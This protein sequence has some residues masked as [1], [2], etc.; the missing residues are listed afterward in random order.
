MGWQTCSRNYN[1]HV[2]RLPR[3]RLTVC[4]GSASHKHVPSFAF[5]AYWMHFL[6]F[7]SSP[8]L[9]STPT[10]GECKER[11]FIILIRSRPNE[12][13]RRRR[14]R[15]GGKKIKF[16]PA[17]EEHPDHPPSG[18]GILCSQNAAFFAAPIAAVPGSE[19]SRDEAQV[20]IVAEVTPSNYLRGAKYF[21][22]VNHLPTAG[23][24]TTA[25][26]AHGFR[27]PASAQDSL[28]PGQKPYP[29]ASWLP[30]GERY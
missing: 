7:V 20:F 8:P 12:N 4:H 14:S 22:Y 2:K 3:V 13:W 28:A 15:S 19:T 1:P 5:D 17:P 26:G 24:E 9:S 16:P 23:E 30:C 29:K 11:C 18:E 27:F 25:V 10:A 21:N 6:T